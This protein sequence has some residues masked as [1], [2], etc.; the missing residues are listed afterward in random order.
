MTRPSR[1]VSLLLLASLAKAVAAGPGLPATTK[2]TASAIDNISRTSDG[3]TSQ[4]A[5]MYS[6]E[7][8]TDWHRQLDRDWQF[9]AAAF[10]AYDRVP[11]F[12]RLDTVRGGAAATLRRKF[13]LGPLAPVVEITA[14]ATRESVAEGGR[15]GWEMTGSIRVAKRFTESWRASLEGARSQ[16]DAARHPFDVR[17]KRI[18][19]ETTW[20]VDEHWQIGFGKGRAWGELTADAAWPIYG[21]ALGGVFGPAIRDYYRAIPWE[22]TNTYGPGWVAYRVNARTDFWWLS[23]SPALADHTSLP[24]RFEE[25]S[26]VNRVGVHYKTR[27]LSLSLIH[28]Y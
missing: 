20:D 3:P 10:I 24:L 15:S 17:Q 16:Y 11:E 4:D 2:V 6:A 28:R 14:G 5:K 19:F 8:A 7:V 9:A 12:R 25:Y 26:V 13:G 21:Q 1:L 18:T 27:I 22:V 23:L